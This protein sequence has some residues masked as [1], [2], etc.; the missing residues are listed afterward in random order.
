MDFKDMG[1]RKKSQTGKAKCMVPSTGNIQ[2]KQW[3]WGLLWG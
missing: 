2:N 3:G 1:L